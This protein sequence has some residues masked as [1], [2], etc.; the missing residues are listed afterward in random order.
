MPVG[1]PALFDPGNDDLYEFLEFTSLPDS[2]EIP[3]DP[4]FAGSFVISAI[5][6]L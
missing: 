2:L 1:S 4:R 6:G 3:R 5:F